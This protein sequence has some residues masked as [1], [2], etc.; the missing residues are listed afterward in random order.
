MLVNITNTFTFLQFPY[1]Q[2]L[3]YILKQTRL[4]RVIE[5]TIRADNDNL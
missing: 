4:K 2:D 3:N 5:N 1:F